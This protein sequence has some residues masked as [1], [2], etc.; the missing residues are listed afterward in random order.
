MAAKY[1]VT[2]TDYGSSLIAQAHNVVSIE[3]TSMVIGDANNQPYEPI[4]QKGRTSLINE[5]ARVPIQSVK[6]IGQIAQVSATIE[7]NIGGFNM[8]EY[9][10]IDTTGQLVYIANFHGAYKPAIAEGAGGELEIVTD[11]KVDSGAQVLVQID[12]NIV[13]ANKKWVLEQLELLKTTRIT[14]HD[15][16]VGDLFLT[17]KRFNTAEEVAEFKSYG[18]WQR[19]GDGHALVTSAQSENENTPS[20]MLD[21]LE[22]GGSNSMTL[23]EH[24]LPAHSHQF[25][26]SWAGSRNSSTELPP[27][28]VRIGDSDG[29]GNDDEQDSMLLRTTTSAGLG[30][31]FSIMQKSIIIDAWKRIA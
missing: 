24:N 20:W 30:I 31:P 3:L 17:T 22:T 26:D 6:V 15:I 28:A 11:I 4:T 25:T 2:L 16:D 27:D 9:G 5:R 19:F 7:A 12:P 14:R 8:H 21:I 23:E 29:Y 18:T 1:Y 13:T 10:F